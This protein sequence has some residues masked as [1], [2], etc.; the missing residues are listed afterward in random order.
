VATVNVE[1]LVKRGSLPTRFGEVTLAALPLNPPEQET[2]MDFIFHANAH[3]KNKKKKKK[4]KK[5]EF[6]IPFFTLW[7]NRESSNFIN[8]NH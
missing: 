7:L 4:K 6:L 8:M 1:V 5:K 3:K 2:S